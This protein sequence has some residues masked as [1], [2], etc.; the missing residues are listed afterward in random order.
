VR[1][2]FR[3]RVKFVTRLAPNRRLFKDVAY[4]ILP[5]LL[6]SEN[7]VRYGNR[8]LYIRKEIVNIYGNTGFAYV[9]IDMDSR[10]QQIKRVAFSALDD[11]LSPKDMD[12]KMARLGLFMIVSSE[13][14]PTDEVLPI[15]YTRQQIEQVF[16][17]GKNGA[18][19][20]PIRVQTEETFRGHLML[21]FLATVVLQKLQRDIIKKSKKKDKIN[22]EGATMVLRNQK[23][24]VFDEAVVPQ[25]AVKNVNDVYRLF[26]IHC[27]AVM[28][29]CSKNSA[30]N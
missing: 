7:A 13:D 8:L 12:D 24:K 16:D 21:T 29:K 18:D 20:L 25:E 15:Y 4:A 26:G 22:P 10:S 28:A 1:E 6:D 2:L 14:I 17:V 5:G 30:G 19:L 27:P 11:R 23:C 3:N 9:G